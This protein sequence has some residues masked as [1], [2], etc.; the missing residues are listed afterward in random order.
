LKIKKKKVGGDT[1]ETFQNGKISTNVIIND[2]ERKTYK[3]KIDR[4]FA[5]DVSKTGL[6]SL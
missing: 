4:N 1:I 2:E 6:F 5:N 3:Y